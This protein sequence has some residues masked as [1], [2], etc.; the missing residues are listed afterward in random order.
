MWNRGGRR[1]V[2]S[3]DEASGKY[4]GKLKIAREARRVVQ[5][6]SLYNVSPHVIPTFCVSNHVTSAIARS[7]ILIG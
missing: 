7:P 3:R 4:L 5:N 1:E 2:W 6:L